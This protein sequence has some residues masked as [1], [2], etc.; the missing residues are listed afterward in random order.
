MKEVPVIILIKEEG[1]SEYINTDTIKTLTVEQI[2]GSEYFLIKVD[3][4]ASQLKLGKDQAVK[5]NDKMRE[6]RQ[7]ELNGQK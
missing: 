3:G 5:L 6:I 1:I 4:I 2:V 7:L